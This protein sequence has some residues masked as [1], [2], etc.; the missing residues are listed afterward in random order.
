MR[1]AVSRLKSPPSTLCALLVLADSLQA[2]QTRGCVG[3][4]AT[5]LGADP[6]GACHVCFSL[7][8]SRLPSASL[9]PPRLLLTLGV[10]V[11]P[12]PPVRTHNRALP[13]HRII[14][15]GGGDKDNDY[16]YLFKSACNS[17]RGPPA[18]FVPYEKGEGVCSATMLKV[19]PW[20]PPSTRPLPHPHPCSR[21]DR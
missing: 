19:S 11:T 8:C 20:V 5:A 7:F 14:M 9:P 3:F 21:S 1:D 16:D 18:L 2:V 4:M 12:C 10:P 6:K 13:P 17:A 15:S